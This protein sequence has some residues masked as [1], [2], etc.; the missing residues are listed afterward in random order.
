MNEQETPKVVNTVSLNGNILPDM[1][2]I[3]GAICDRKCGYGAHGTVRRAKVNVIL[4]EDP[5][6]ALM[7]EGCQ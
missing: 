7:C 6:D 5:M 4:P 1:C 3:D 2:P